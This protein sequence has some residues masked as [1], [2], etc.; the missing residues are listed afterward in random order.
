MPLH[1]LTFVTLG[2][3]NVEQTAAYY[4]E[5]GL[6]PSATETVSIYGESRPAPSGAHSFSTTDG[7]EQLRIVP[8]RRRR[9]VE[10]GVG[11]H[12]RDDLDRVSAQLSRL[13]LE[14]VR[15]D[16]SLRVL[17]P[18]TD[19]NVVVSIA[20]ELAQ[21]AVPPASSNGPG[22][23]DRTGARADAVLRD[24]RVRPH[25][26]GHVVIGSTDQQASQTFFTAGLGFKTS[27]EVRGLAA[28]LR[29]TT[30]HHN[31]LVQQSPVPLL[32]H[33]VAGRRRRRDRAR[34]QRHARRR[35]RPARLGSGS[36]PHRLKLLLVPE[37]PR[38]QLQR[39][40]LRHRLHHRRP[41]MDATRLGWDEEPLQLG[42]APAPVLH[43]TRRPHRADGRTAC[44]HHLHVTAAPRDDKGRL[45]ADVLVVGYRPV[46]QIA[47]VLLAPTR[48]A[49]HC[50][51]TA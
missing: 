17:D 19:L 26:L 7:G 16:T 18:G 6:T 50:R 44:G 11:C 15:D 3:P 45:D 35:P 40:L 12:N 10:L 32:H 23:T 13:D 1:R 27:D 46:G 8:A 48:L 5:F 24:D 42:P 36:P 29:C 22:R 34:G 30:D 14:V 9:L 51:G 39:V 4:E 31:V 21:G 20:E 37:G 43:C 47:A 41:A 25:K 38:R 28:F 49:G 2:V 33:L